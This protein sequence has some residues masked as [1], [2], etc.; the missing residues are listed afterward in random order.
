MQNELTTE[1]MFRHWWRTRQHNNRQ[2]NNT[3]K[4]KNSSTSG[5]NDNKC[6]N[7]RNNNNNTN[8]DHNNAD[9]SFHSMSGKHNTAALS[10]PHTEMHTHTHG[11]SLMV[12][13]LL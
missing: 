7:D 1:A 2:K 4:N 13:L 10:E 6:N 9:D 8:A 5:S 12:I 3:R 11:A